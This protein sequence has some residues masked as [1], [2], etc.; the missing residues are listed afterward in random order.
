MPPSLP[1]SRL[2]PSTATHSTSQ[3]RPTASYPISTRLILLL[4]L[5]AIVVAMVRMHN[6]K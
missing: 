5:T 3:L 6:L 1:T 2:T 4:L